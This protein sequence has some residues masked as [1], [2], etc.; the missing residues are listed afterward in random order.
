MK[1][2]CLILFVM[3]SVTYGCIRWCFESCTIFSKRSMLQIKTQVF[4][5]IR[6]E[7]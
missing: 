6:R 5:K 1:D 4:C 7:V 2:D 3:S